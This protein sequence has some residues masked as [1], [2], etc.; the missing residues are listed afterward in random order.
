[1]NDVH[2]NSCCFIEL[3]CGTLRSTILLVV[4]EV[5]AQLPA[6]R[7]RLQMVGLTAGFSSV[8]GDQEYLRTV[9]GLSAEAIATAV[10]SRLRSGPSQLLA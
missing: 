2:T 7:A 1:M 4:A 6:S 10:R 3:V 5:L 8:V 9:Y